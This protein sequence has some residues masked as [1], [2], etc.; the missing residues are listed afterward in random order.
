MNTS[1]PK[2]SPQSMPKWRAY[3][4]LMRLHRPIGIYL[5]LWPTLWSLWLAAGGVPRWDLLVIFTVGVVLMRSAGCVINDYADRKVDGHVERTRSRPLVTG[6]VSPIEAAALFAVLSLASFLLVLQTNDLTVY[7]SVGGIALA[8][9]YPFMKRYTQLPQVV[10][11]AAFA[12]SVP[13]AFAAQTGE[14]S[15]DIWLLYTAVLLWTVA[16]DTF[17]AMVDRDDDLKIGVKSSAIL[18]GEQDKAITAC[19]QLMTLIAL[20]M[21]GTKFELGTFYYLSLAAAAGLMIYQ[22]LLIRERKRD[23][24]FKAFLNNNWVGIV[25]FVGIVCDYQFR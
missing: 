16:Y 8:F 14:L 18:F 24:C 12:W 20:I 17:Y 4:Q 15:S 3:L 9:C 2:V 10:L 1:S 13:M 21:V 22:Q 5:V 23:A 25:I 7:L 19:L 6:L 11:G